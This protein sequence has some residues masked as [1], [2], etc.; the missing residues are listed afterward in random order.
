MKRTWLMTG[1]VLTAMLMVGL[2]GAGAANMM[3]A[4]PTAMAV[5]NPQKLFDNLEEKRQL[6]ATM[7]EEA[8]RIRAEEQRRSR[9]IE[10]LQFELEAL[11]ANDPAYRAKEEELQKAA[12][13][14]QVWL[15]FQQQRIN[16]ERGV[17]MED[18]YRKMLNGI[19]RVATTNGYDMVL[20]KEVH[21]PVFNYENPQQL[22]A[23]IQLRKVLWSKDDMD[24][25]DLVAQ[26]MNNEFRARQR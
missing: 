9:H 8:E 23:L 26:H 12:I 21:P 19:G 14:L 7:T 20:Y 25:T 18:I 13:E 4:R 24:I 6:D 16:R 1:I 3:Q 15:R 10:N 11:P 22:S 2:G 5:V 17:Q